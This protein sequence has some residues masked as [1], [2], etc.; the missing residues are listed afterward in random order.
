MVKV[1]LKIQFSI[2]NS[3]GKGKTMAAKPNM[4]KFVEV[5]G[6]EPFTIH[7]EDGSVEYDERMLAE[8]SF[9]DEPYEEPESAGA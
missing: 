1:Q 6:F 5:F 2:F 7:R 3:R 8:C 4:Q 9:W